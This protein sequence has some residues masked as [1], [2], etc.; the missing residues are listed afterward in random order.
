MTAFS[1]YRYVDTISRK[2]KFLRLV[3]EIV[4]LLFFRPTPRWA[5]H[6]WRRTLLRLF[7]A[8]IGA[9]CRI[10][11]SC[12]VW[13]PWN[14]EMGSFSALA[15]HVDCYTMDKIRIG[16]KVAVSQRA[17]LCSGSH[18]TDTL[19]R[20]L[21]TS[22]ITIDDHVWIAAECFVHPGTHIGEGCVVGARSVVTKDLPEWTICAGMPCKP[23]KERKIVS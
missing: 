20:E 10:A 2:S 12:K 4:W 6:G 19:I 16:S 13:A 1:E 21:V 18:R 5:L 15:D 3:W 9:G 23:L 17:F 7:G 11:P 22:P 14:L 8:R